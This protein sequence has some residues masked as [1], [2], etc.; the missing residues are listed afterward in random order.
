MI[1]RALVVASLVLIAAGAAA[2]TEPPPPLSRLPVGTS[3]LT[4]P[5]TQ[6][7]GERS[8]EMKFTHRFRQSLNQGS[9]GDQIHSLFGLD[10]N[11]DVVFGFAY[12]LGPDLQLSIARSNT[13]DTIETAA[14]FGALRQSARVPL[15]VTLRGGADWRTERNL[16][17]RSSFFA[18]AIVSRQFG[19]KAELFA[20]PTM[21]TNAGRVVTA[22]ASA[23]MFDYAFNIPVGAVVMIRPAIAVVAELIPPNRSLPD[24][25][26]A[27]LGWALGV[28]RKMGGHWFEILLTNSQASTADQY[29]TSTFQGNGLV[30]SDIHLGFNIQR[31]FVRRR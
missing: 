3:L 19:R 2:Q 10:T 23:A 21:V 8:W 5:S 28:K 9:L 17:D 31:R 22:D 4:L 18:Q 1:E 7:L 12:A 27:D 29:V 26:S 15:N 13:N 16:D 6:T 30:G 24:G 14:T 20:L 11:A 25:I